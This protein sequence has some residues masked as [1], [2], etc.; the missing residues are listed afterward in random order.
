[1]GKGGRPSSNPEDANYDQ[2]YDPTF[3]YHNEWK[4]LIYSR[5]EE[6]QMRSVMDTSM[7]A[8]AQVFANKRTYLY[9]TRYYALLNKIRE[10]RK[11]QVLSR[12][13]AKI[14]NPLQYKQQFKGGFNLGFVNTTLGVGAIAGM[15]F[16]L[17]RLKA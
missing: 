3:E 13:N 4:G 15:A 5:E 1:M 16:A 17:K 7:P 2:D 14:E 12:I 9:Y 10:V 6:H 11:E 8:Q